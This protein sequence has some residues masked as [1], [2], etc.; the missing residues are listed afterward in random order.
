ML[1]NNAEETI[2][3]AVFNFERA[4]ANKLRKLYSLPVDELKAREKDELIKL[5][6]SMDSD[7]RKVVRGML[8]DLNAEY[9]ETILRKV[10]EDSDVPD[11]VSID[12]DSVDNAGKDEYVRVVSDQDKKKFDIGLPILIGAGCL[13]VGSIVM[14]C[15]IPAG[16][17]LQKIFVVGLVASAVA[18]GF[19]VLKK[20]FSRE[21]NT[22]IEPQK[23]PPVKKDYKTAI[24]VSLRGNLS[25]LHKWCQRLQRNIFQVLEGEMG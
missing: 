12:W 9:P 24:D 4:E 2:R 15:L 20:L 25:E 11:F 8:N 16:N 14:L 3:V 19:V 7:A 10:F 6:L 18:G 13:A 23:L 1:S 17:P 5:T 22:N 21:K